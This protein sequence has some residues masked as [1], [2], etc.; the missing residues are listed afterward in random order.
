VESTEDERAASARTVEPLH[1]EARKRF[2][3]DVF[4]LLRA[5]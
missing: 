1:D 5:G 3:E 4:A 2:G